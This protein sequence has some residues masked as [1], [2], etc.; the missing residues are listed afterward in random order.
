[1]PLTSSLNQQLSQARQQKSW[2]VE[3]V[4]RQLNLPPATVRALENADYQCLH[5]DAFVIAYLRSYAALLS[6]N[7][8]DLVDSYRHQRSQQQVEQ[9]E[10]NLLTAA[11]IKAQHKKYR[12]GYGIAASVALVVMLG[13]LSPDVVK[14]QGEHTHVD[15]VV[16]T[17]A[18]TTRIS[19]L[20]GLPE[21]NPTLALMPEVSLLTVADSQQTDDKQLIQDLSQLRFHFSADCWVEVVDGDNRKI[22]SSLQKTDQVL[23]LTGKP[24]FRITLGYAPGVEL[25]YNGQPVD[26]DASASNLA[27]LVLGN[28]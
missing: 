25:S 2:S 17:A 10:N 15:I 5:G 27:R 21:D 23:Q 9:Q 16:D 3:Y 13:I 24:P 26:I 14:Q 19:S 4:A 28:S 7:A 18:G 11:Y 1:M 12:T 20:E 22:F 6:L 8:D